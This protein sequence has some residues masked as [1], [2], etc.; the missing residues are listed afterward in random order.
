MSR[1]DDEART[2]GGG[3]A[4]EREEVALLARV[5]ARDKAAFE[6]L[7]RLYFRRLGRFLDR[8]TRRADLVEEILNDVMLVVWHRADTFSHESRVSTWIFAIAWRQ[9]MKRVQ[10]A[11]LPEA[12]AAEAAAV[13]GDASASPE[14]QAILRQ[15]ASQLRAALERLP[16]EQRMTVEL[17]YFHGYG[18]PE[19]ARIMD[20]PTDTVKTRMFHAR[21]KL[22]LMLEASHGR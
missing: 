10:R 3:A 2:E 11:Q 14:T 20:C 6:Q 21:R 5:C 12:T 13:E 18:Y 17:T 19:I 9:A 15:S 16:V 1:L 7:Y 8:I 22:R 4:G